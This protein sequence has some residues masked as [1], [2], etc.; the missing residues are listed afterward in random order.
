LA[1]DIAAEKKGQISIIATDI[2]DA[3]CDAFMRLNGGLKPTLLQ[4]PVGRT[5]Q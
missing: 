5:A 1:G 2:I 4:K 3:L